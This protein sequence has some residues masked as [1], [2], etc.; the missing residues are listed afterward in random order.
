MTASEPRHITSNTALAEHCEQW[1][2]HALI[3]LDTEFV[4][5]TT[6]YPI[7]GLVQVGVDGLQYLVDPL[8]IDDWGPLQSLLADPIPKVLHACGEDIEVFQRLLGVVPQPMYDTQVGAALTGWGFGLGYQ[9]LVQQVL[10]IH[11][12]KEHTRSNWVAR[13]LSPEQCHYAALD[14]AYL[15]ELYA[16]ISERLDRLGRLTWWRE[17]GERAVR[18]GLRQADPAMYYQKLGAGFRLRGRQ[19]AVLQQLCLWRET[20]ARRLN[21]PRGRILKDAE[22]LE[23]ARRLPQSVVELGRIPDMNPQHVRAFGVAVLALIESVGADAEATAPIEAPLPR[24]WGSRLN[25]LRELVAERAKELD[26]PP[27]L[28][29]RKRDCEYLL[30]TGQLPEPLQGWRFAAVGEDLLTLSIS[31]T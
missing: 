26:L 2:Q 24:E 25:R 22:C 14:V 15:P 13:P 12:D 27:E 29:V 21:M 5:E 11:V 6:F 30:R 7:P 3:T 28:L 19:V 1:R 8:A 16:R 31:L 9:A 17:E 23:V 20:E 18:L 10:G 4:R